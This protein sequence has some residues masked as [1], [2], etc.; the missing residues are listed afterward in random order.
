MCLQLEHVVVGLRALLDTSLQKQNQ[1]QKHQSGHLLL[2][3]RHA[4]KPVMPE[5]P[6]ARKERTF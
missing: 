5:F 2:D 1:N 6:C 3:R 4:T